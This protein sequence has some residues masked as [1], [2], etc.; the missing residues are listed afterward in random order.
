MEMVKSYK[1]DHV[2]NC[3][4][5]DM[6]QVLRPFSLLNYAQEMAYRHSTLQ[7]FGYDDLIGRNLGWVLSRVYADIIKAPKWKDKISIETW[8]KGQDRLFSVRDFIIRDVNTGEALIKMT[9][10]W[11]IIN[12]ESRRIHRFER[13]VD[14][15]ADVE[16]YILHEDAVRSPAYKIEMPENPVHA[17][18][19]MVKY[20]DVDFNRHVNNAKYIEWSMD[21]ILDDIPEGSSLKSFCINFNDEAVLGDRISFFKAV[22][23]VEKDGTGER[24]IFMDG[25]KDDMQNFTVEMVYA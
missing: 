1:E 12:F 7:G 24:H 21:R 15:N 23:D 25:C 19:H 6:F 18:S 5:T 9:T 16:D 22:K 10:S 11:L 13:V 20:S 17:D 2:V 4:E 8:H 3:Y 14:E